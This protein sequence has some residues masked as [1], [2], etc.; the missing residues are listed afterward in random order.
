MT[1]KEGVP[2]IIIRNVLHPS[3]GNKKTFGVTAHTWR[4]EQVAALNSDGDETDTTALHLI[5]FQLSFHDVKATHIQFTLRP[6]FDGTAH[7]RR[8]QKLKKLVLN[9]RSSLFYPRKLHVALS[10]VK[11]S[12]DRF[13]LHKQNNTTYNASAGHEILVTVANLLLKEAV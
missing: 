13:L 6:A 2:V 8:G 1:L 11:K 10:Q 3:L 7:N 4:L 12:T 9:L 5:M